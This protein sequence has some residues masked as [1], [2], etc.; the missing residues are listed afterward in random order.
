MGE[1]RIGK[2]GFFGGRGE[3]TGVGVGAKWEGLYTEK[4][5]EVNFILEVGRALERVLERIFG[6][7]FLRA[8]SSR[9][10]LPSTRKP[11]FRRV[12]S[13]QMHG[14]FAGLQMLSARPSKMISCWRTL[15][16]IPVL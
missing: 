10:Q 15:K 13:S 8:V 14:K 1:T 2:M 16:A 11:M 7:F 4:S 9:V 3:D 6:G 5:R 12:S